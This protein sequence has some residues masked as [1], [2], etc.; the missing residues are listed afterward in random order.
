[1]HARAQ[2]L[3]CGAMQSFEGKLHNPACGP[4]PI[5]SFRL[6]LP[7]S[8]VKLRVAKLHLSADAADRMCLLLYHPP[9]YTRGIS[10]VR[11]SF[12]DFAG[13]RQALRIRACKSDIPCDASQSQSMICIAVFGHRG[14]DLAMGSGSFS[15]T[16]QPL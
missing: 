8:A 4:S 11:I 9:P 6:S 3:A 10:G 15:P 2:R 14:R 5:C 16:R 12:T 7:L 13:A 1:M